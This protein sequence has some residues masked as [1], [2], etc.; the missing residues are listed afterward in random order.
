MKSLEVENKGLSEKYLKTD[1]KCIKLEE[2]V[3]KLE[4][5][6]KTLQYRNITMEQMI[7]QK[8][9]VVE[10]FTNLEGMK[11]KQKIMAIIRSKRIM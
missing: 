2:K 4:A 9:E 7:H 1:G 11:K 6:N 3:K 8:D 5:R 10:I